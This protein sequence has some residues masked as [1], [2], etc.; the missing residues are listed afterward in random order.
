MNI[1][2]SSENNHTIVSIDGKVDTNTSPELEKTLSEL[3]EAGEVNLL[4]DFEHLSFISS[5]G[6]RV[7][8]A[9]AKKTK[10]QSGSLKVC[11]LNPTVKEVFDISGFST[12]LA[13]FPDRA[14]AL[15][16]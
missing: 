1:T 3:V 2:T 10:A 9:T 4:A 16:S 12:I 15:G 14:S 13:V 7:L 6:L 8:L 11:A 5:A